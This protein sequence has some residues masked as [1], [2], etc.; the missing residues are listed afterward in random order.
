MSELQGSVDAAGSAAGKKIGQNCSYFGKCKQLLPSN[1]QVLSLQ[2][3]IVTTILKISPPQGASPVFIHKRWGKISPLTHASHVSEC[4]LK[5]T[6]LRSKPVMTNC[7]PRSVWKQQGVDLRTQVFWMKIHDRK[8]NEWNTWVRNK[9]SGWCISLALSLQT[10][11]DSTKN[12][13]T[14][15]VRCMAIWQNTAL[16]YVDH[17]SSQCFFKS[18]FFGK[19]RC[20]SVLLKVWK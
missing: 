1:K 17:A 18:S 16:I 19:A 2:L 20:C 5:T 9:H 11:I 8:P 3:W 7:G 13:H 14:V 12:G 10:T 4:V 15:A 6:F